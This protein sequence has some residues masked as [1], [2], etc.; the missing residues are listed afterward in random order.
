MSRL[1]SV[2][3]PGKHGRHAVSKFRRTVFITIAMEDSKRSNL[4]AEIK[5][6]KTVS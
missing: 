6:L 3:K 5:K 2:D 1:S 4:A